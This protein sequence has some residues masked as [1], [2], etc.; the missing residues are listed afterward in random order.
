MDLSSRQR[1]RRR[2]LA[3][4]GAA[5]LAV[6]SVSATPAGPDAT[7]AA[8]LAGVRAFRGERYEE[9]LA[10][11]RRLQAGG[12]VPDIGLYL[13][14]TLHKLGQHAEALGAFRL[15]RQ[16]GVQEPV[17]DYYQAVSCYRLGLLLRAQKILTRLEQGAVLG[18]RLQ[19]GAGRFLQAINTS[20]PQPALP[21]RYEAAIARAEGLLPGAPAEAVEWIE[22]AAELGRRL[23]PRLAQR[24]RLAQ[25]LS[26]AL[27]AAP[28]L[29]P[30]TRE[31]PPLLDPP[32]RSLDEGQPG[33]G[34]P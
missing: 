28:G 12:Q 31:I 1:P 13:G 14:M 15:A 2:S 3:I 9:A 30:L 24:A 26:R 18:P 16:A 7:Q 5:L 6:L 10:T 29:A 33:Q 11:F 17:A 25:A 23:P 4:L 19:A 21:L 20:L 22:E 32:L 27:A 34:A 8:L